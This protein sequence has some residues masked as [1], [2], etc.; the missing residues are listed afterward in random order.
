MGG[1][2]K[3]CQAEIK[4]IQKIAFKKPFAMAKKA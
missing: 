4:N 3:K 2:K 1:D